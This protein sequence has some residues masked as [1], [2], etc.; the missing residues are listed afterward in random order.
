MLWDKQARVFRMTHRDTQ[1]MH[2]LTKLTSPADAVHAPCFRFPGM[3]WDKQARVFRMHTAQSYPAP[4][5]TSLLMHCIPLASGSR[6][7]VG[8]AGKGVAHDAQ[9]KHILPKLNLFC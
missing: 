5:S 8:Q 1:R 3:L 2:I 7:A 9:R 4:T 6:D